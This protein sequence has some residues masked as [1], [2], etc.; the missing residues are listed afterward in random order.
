MPAREWEELV[1]QLESFGMASGADPKRA[2]MLVVTDGGAPD[3]RQRSQLGR[4]WGGK[5]IQT[6]VMVPGMSNPLK[7]GLMTALTWFNPRMAFFVPTQLAD[8]L[9]HV[10][11]AEAQGKLWS[12]LLV[13]QRQLPPVRTLQLIAAAAQLPM[14]SAKGLQRVL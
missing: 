4:L 13:L 9:Q 1:A 14:D 10:G 6:A 12:S 7:R 8:A 11:L 2:R 3:A 5:S